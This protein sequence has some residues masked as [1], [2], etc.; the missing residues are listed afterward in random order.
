[1]GQPAQTARHLDAALGSKINGIYGI[2]KVMN[3]RS[4][5]ASGITADLPI[6]PVIDA[7]RAALRDGRGVVLQAPPG[8]GKTTRVPLALLDEQWLAGRRI[9]VLEPR[10]LATRAAARRMAALRGENV[11]ETI[12]YRM[13]MDSAI[14]PRTRIEVVTDGILIRMLQDDPALDGI[15]A[16]IF[17]EFHERSLD[18]DLGLA[19]CL[20]ARR[21]LRDDL[22]LAIMSATLDGARVATLLG[23]APVI[24]SEGRSFPVAT[25]Y[26]AP[27]A[28]AR[29]EDRV[30]AGI[31]RALAETAGS[32]LVFLPGAGEIRR[33][34]R[35]LDEM[36]LGPDIRIAPLYGELAQAA[37]DAALLPAPPGLRKI[38]LATSI[39]ETSLTIEGIGVVIDGGLMRVP[40][41]E[42]RSG[43]TRLETVK[44][45]QASADQRRGRAGRLAPGTCYRLW[46]ENEQRLL[47]RF[48]APEIL[49]ADLAPL[50]LDLARWGAAAADLAWLD[51]PP[52]AALAQAGA[53]LAGLGAIDAAGRITPHGTA[54]AGLGLHPRLAHMIL[55]GAARGAGALACDIAALIS[56]RDV[57]KAKPGARDA[58][59]RLRLE[60]I[61]GEAGELPGLSVDRF[62][63]RQVRQQAA[64]WRRR[65]R[66]SATRGNLDQAGSLLA[67]AYP[68]RIAQ[69][70]PGGGGQFRLSNGRGASL[71]PTDPLAG[72]DYLAVAELD[73]DKRE[74]R[75]FLAA[76]LSLAAVEEIFADRLERRDI[77]VWEP[78]ENAV[79]ARRQVRL[80]E[81]VLRDEGLPKPP[82]ETVVAMLTGAI[83]ESGLAVLPWRKEV[84]QFRA[85]AM[86]LRRVEGVEGGWPD[87][88]DEAL[89][90]TLEDWLAPALDGIM[91]FAHLERID[92]GALLRARLDWAQLRALDERAPSHATVPSGSRL[93]IDY[94]EGEAPILAVR[95]QEMFGA[96]ATPRIAGGKV[97]LRLQL[98]SPAGR[99]L[100]VTSDLAGFWATSYRAVRAEMRGR[101]P[102]HPWPD[103]PLA[104]PPTRRAKPRVG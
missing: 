1:M 80:G 26:L 69:R 10:R 98:L 16:V 59:L 53:L 101:Y 14:G 67:L 36:A 49:A 35:R 99:P 2:N 103:D 87:L 11:G 9:L 93:A 52:E 25:R 42:P 47:P 22:R 61:G 76:A 46:S 71:P 75:I 51:P 68:D 57:V 63:L 62:L 45:S 43:M 15:G 30:V 66:V 89:L 100:Q 27:Q 92:L 13:R 39:A 3:E 33:V 48:N 97:A 82:R 20:E 90:A 6:E 74:A 56:L 5:D 23:D 81:L 55:A 78:R 29:F 38:V 34:E 72:V 21:H 70:R 37:Q 60:L 102:K 94:A 91:R 7:L 19:L 54:M 104:E 96:A 84:T 65:V 83:R 85:R 86:F 73:G 64:E 44:V 58:D 79:L 31:G 88:G 95:L 8:A 4:R 41:F 50:A 24:A 17:D 77:V 28:G 18:A 40:R 12:G 32:L